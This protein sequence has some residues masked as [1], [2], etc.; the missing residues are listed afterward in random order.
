MFLA[1]GLLVSILSRGYQLPNII[2]EAA[3]RTQF[4]GAEHNWTKLKKTASL[5]ISEIFPTQF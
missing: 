5:A 2:R 4:R 1:P 3:F